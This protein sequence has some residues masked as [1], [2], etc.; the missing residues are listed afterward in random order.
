V[1]VAPFAVPSKT[2]TLSLLTLELDF[3]TRGKGKT[4]E[5]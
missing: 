1:Q 4:E 3:I 5:V 2:F